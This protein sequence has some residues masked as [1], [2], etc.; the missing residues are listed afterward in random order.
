M[1]ATREMTLGYALLC[2]A[3]SR[4]SAHGDVDAESIWMRH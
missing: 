4:S 3:S 2:Q 1:P